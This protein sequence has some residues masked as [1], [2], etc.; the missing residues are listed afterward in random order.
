MEVTNLSLRD[1]TEGG[2]A[3]AL[4]VL[5][6]EAAGI[7]DLIE[8]LDENFTRALLLLDKVTGRVIVSGMGKS[9]HVARK[10]AA[11][12]A[13]TGT[14][15]TFVHPA[16]ASH[17]DL[18]MVTEH[19]AVVALS[20]SGETAELADL[21]TYAKR[22]GIPLIGITGRG[23]STLAGAADVALVLPDSPEAC[24]MGLAPT[25]STTVMLA[26][27]DAIA[28][29]LLERKGFSAD[30]FHLLHPGGKLG[31][32]LLRVGAI[33]HAQDAVPLARRDIPM[34]EALLIMTAKSFGCVGILDD[35]G[36]L[37]GIVTDG[38]LRR[39]MSDNL[40][41]LT[42]GEVMTPHPRTISPDALASEALAVMNARS[43]TNLF[44]VEE[45]CPVGIIHVHDC[46]RAGVA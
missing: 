10:I 4:R 18:G 27:G 43:I 16:E 21:I 33:M 3:S 17:G 40:L 23:D 32:M 24:P 38:D 13:S 31:R 1:G 28:V 42:T 41:A 15:A 7:M 35:A 11:T 12:F 9:G 8:S 37:E 25:T 6:M 29:A 2:L 19:D 39:H 34:S 14:P 45:R 44:V 22:F 36:R 46:L 5:R 20:N 26:L 30:D